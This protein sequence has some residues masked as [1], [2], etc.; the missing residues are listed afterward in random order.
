MANIPSNVSFG[1]VKARFVLAFSDSVDGG[2]EPDAIPAQGSV[3]FNAS[4]ILLKNTTA[5]PDPV[6]ILP[7]GVEVVLDEDGYLR[8]FA[9]QDGLGVR[10][11]ATDDPDN[12][13]VNWTWS[14]T[15]RLTDATGTPVSLPSF[16]F[17]LPS[18]T[19]ID[20]TE[21]SPVPDAN[22]TFN[23][24]GPAGATGATGATGAQGSTG[25]TGAQGPQGEQGVQ[26]TQGETGSQG[27]AGSITNL[28]VDS[29]ITYDVQTSTVGLDY[30]ALVIDGGTA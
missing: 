28:N 25:A 27:P 17:S 1:T 6:T 26:G 18:N 12:E 23:I 30:D 2:L 21:V 8:S 20:L 16:S 5:S 24:V 9:G 19:T 11:V 10:L 14:V 4:P 13:P 15:F 29:P 7:A 22:G 3:F